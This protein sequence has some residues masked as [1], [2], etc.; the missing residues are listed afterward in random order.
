MHVKGFRNFAFGSEFFR[1]YPC[2][3]NLKDESNI[4]RLAV[5][6]W[7]VFLGKALYAVGL[8]VG[9]LKFY[10]YKKNYFVTPRCNTSW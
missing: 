6:F 5:A 4:I 7:V 9:R 2:A 8:I 3:G 10:F 1:K